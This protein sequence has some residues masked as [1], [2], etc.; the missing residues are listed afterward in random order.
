[1]FDSKLQLSTA[2]PDAIERPSSR[3]RRKQVPA[4]GRP[5]AAR[6]LDEESVTMLE[7]IAECER[8][9]RAL[10]REQLTTIAAYALRQREE[11]AQIGADLGSVRLGPDGDELVERAIAMEVAATL[12]LSATSARMLVTDAS[13][14]TDHHQEVL[15][16][17]DH[18]RVSL[19]TA[20]QI[21]SGTRVL[22]STVA[23]S[24][25]AELAAEAETL[26]PGQVRAMVDARVIAADPAAAARRAALA[27]DDKHLSLRPQPDTVATL[28]ATLPAEQALACYQAIDAHA[29]ALRAAGDSRSLDHLR[30]DTLVERLTGAVTA[31]DCAVVDLNVVLTDRT[32]LGDSDAP[33]ELAGYGPVPADLARC[34]ATSSRTWLRRLL[35]DPFDGTVT[36]IDTRRR[37]FDGALRTMIRLRDQ[38]CRNPVCNAPI[39]DID[40]RQEH[41]YG[42][43]TT[44]GNA[45]GYCMRCHHLKDHPGVTVA[46]LR[47]QAAGGDGGA[48][49]PDRGTD[50]QHRS[51]AHGIVW[52]GPSGR[53]YPSLAPP[54]LGA[55]RLSLDQLRYRHLLVARWSSVRRS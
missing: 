19:F 29:R 45:D 28:A 3:R 41:A 39:S 42:G 49:P 46:R 26:L 44:S 38:R 15:D 1:M 50:E 23:A 36:T 34:L 13:D 7:R 47:P 35:T 20:R 16:S 21:A 10:Q 53:S 8:H 37:R 17:L 4:P 48:S 43:P 33:A 52:T 25:D 32:L 54:A 55:G 9:I 27:R 22:D 11:S 2:E 30:C 40:H 31:S 51:C 14:L 24:I 6:R 5:G 18:C 12:G